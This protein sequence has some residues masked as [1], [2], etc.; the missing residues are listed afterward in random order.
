MHSKLKL[1]FLLSFLTF[2]TL[3]L[4]SM[5]I[6]LKI[7]NALPENLTMT[8]GFE[9]TIL[10]ALVFLFGLVLS[11]WFSKIFGKLEVAFK[12][13]G[14]GNLQVRLPY[15]KND[16]LSEFYLSFHRMLQAQ[17]ELI[18]HIK[19]SADTLSSDSQ[20]MKLVTLDFSSNLQSQSAA[21]E[22]VSASI[23]EISGVAVSIS[24]IAENNSQS[25]NNLTSEVDNLSMAIDRTSEYVEGTLDSIKNIIDRAEAR[26]KY[27]AY[28]E[29]SY[30]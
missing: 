20:K 13:V 28:N 4:I 7:Q 14:L 17:G 2:G 10:V 9:I 23:E 21:T 15:K 30:G 8:I 11:N 25:M 22:E 16:L 6:V 26:K 5:A 24:N 12:E 27:T 3:L 1:Y 18:Q 29:R 19:T